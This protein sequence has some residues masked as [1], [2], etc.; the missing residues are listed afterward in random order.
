MSG[1]GSFEPVGMD[2]SWRGQGLGRALIRDGFRRLAEKRM[3]S[4]RVST[5]GFNHPAQR[6]YESAGFARVGT[7]RTYLKR[8][9]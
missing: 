4:A 7:L 5:A 3:R 1:V 2:P 9:A 6:L 8:L